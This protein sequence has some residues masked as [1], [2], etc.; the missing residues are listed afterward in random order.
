MICLKFRN[1][2]LKR[3]NER[4]T[5][6]RELLWKSMNFLNRCDDIY[7]MFHQ[8]EVLMK[9]GLMITLTW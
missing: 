7:W 2:F 8:S 9:H 1:Y 3:K 4:I 5:L 6:V